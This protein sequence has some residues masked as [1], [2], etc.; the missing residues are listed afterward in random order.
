[1]V[2]GVLIFL[3][4]DQCPMQVEGFSTRFR[5]IALLA[6]MIYLGF[7]LKDRSPIAL[8]SVWDVLSQ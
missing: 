3:V 6:L 5:L 8:S 1:M 4:L 2:S 7:F